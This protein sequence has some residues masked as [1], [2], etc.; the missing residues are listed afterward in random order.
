MAN[1]SFLRR[2]WNMIRK[3]KPEKELE[4]L[5]VGTS[6][7]DLL[8]VPWQ[9]SYSR[10][11][12]WED[13]DNMDKRDGTM[14]NFCTCSTDEGTFEFKVELDTSKDDHV[15]NDEAEALEIMRT[16]AEESGLQDDSWDI[17]RQTIK[18]G[19]NF[20]E[21]RIDNDYTIRKIQQFPKP[22]QICKNVDEHGDL[23][24][25]DPQKAMD[26]ATKADSAA[27][28][29]YNDTGQVVAAFWPWQIIP[30]SIGHKGGSTY[31]T[32]LL[33]PVTTQWKRLQAQ[34][35]SLAI[36]RITKA[37]DTRI[38]NILV[39]AGLSGDE[40]KNKVKDYRATMEKDMITTYDSS[41]ANFNIGYRENPVDV[42]TDIYVVSY[43]T[44]DGK[45]VEGK[46]D[47][48]RANTGALEN[49]TDIYWS[50][51]RVLAGVGVPQS[52]LN[53]RIGQRSFV[54]KTPEENK[55]AFV[56]MMTRFRA[57]HIMGIR[58]VLDLQLL[59]E[60]I[61]PASIDYLIKYPKIASQ[62]AEMQSDIML[63]KSQAARNWHSIGVPEELI[64]KHPLDFTK[65]EIELWA[66]QVK[67]Q[68]D[69]TK[70]GGDDE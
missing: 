25:G 69:Q 48:L 38:H 35:D 29:Q 41:A 9:R 63:N 32:P 24:T 7:K 12:V 33:A 64:G 18:A 6:K 40:V 19:D 47:V 20:C 70:N 3:S 57:C 45:V 67:K 10:K 65:Q 51:G 60:G 17:L 53:L 2:V 36:A 22:W 21:I 11:G 23:K 39:P 46:V 56:M 54:D 49:I 68:A 8:T 55:E 50:L 5:S 15:S 44:P 14:V 31:T 26:D 52:Y 4:I 13:I 62:S 59:F 30:W 43:Y 37:W 27:Y 61:N 42:D 34:E 16:A 58:Q 1:P 66:G 28:T